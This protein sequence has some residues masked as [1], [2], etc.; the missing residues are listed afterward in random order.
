SYLSDTHNTCRQAPTW[1]W[2]QVKRNCN[3]EGDNQ[4]YYD[5]ASCSGST[6]NSY[7]QRNEWG[8]NVNPA[9]SSAPA[10]YSAA[11]YYNEGS[12]SYSYNGTRTS[13]NPNRY[14]NTRVVTCTYDFS[15]REKQER[16]CK[17]H[18]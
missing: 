2:T 16:L 6:T 7:A 15:D 14:E 18:G 9:A 8:N 1:T 5:Y 4:T 3:Y 17:Y 11:S 12:C 13:R 10:S